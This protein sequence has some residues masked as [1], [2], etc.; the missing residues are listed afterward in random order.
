[1]Y[2]IE[3]EHQYVCESCYDENDYG[4]CEKTECYYS[5]DKLIEVMESDDTV[6]TVLKS[7]LQSITITVI[8]VRNITKIH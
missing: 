6:I 1:M 8:C 3:D 2:Y 7:I 5:S 4:Y